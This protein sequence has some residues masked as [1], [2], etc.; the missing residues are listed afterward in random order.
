MPA[1]KI[2][3]QEVTY[4]RN[5]I[6]GIGFHVVRFQ[7]YDPDIRDSRNMIATV[8]PDEGA[9]AVLDVEQTAQGNVAFAMGNSWRGDNFEPAIR[10]AIEDSSP[11]YLA[12]LAE[13]RTTSR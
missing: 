13:I 3:P 12:E 8:F 5:G 4:H 10:Q 6:G 1:Q 2:L 9:C 7:W 11:G